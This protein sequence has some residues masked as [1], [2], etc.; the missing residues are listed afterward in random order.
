MPSP[1]Q[2]KL[3]PPA[4]RQFINTS[5]M[6]TPLHGVIGQ[7]SPEAFLQLTMQQVSWLRAPS[8]AAPSRAEA[9]ESADPPGVTV[10]WRLLYASP[11]T[12]T[13]SLGISTRF[14]ITP[15]I[16]AR[17]CKAYYSTR[18]YTAVMGFLSTQKLSLEDDCTGAGCG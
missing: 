7:L 8:R 4:R 17:H 14:P 13:G 18:D 1:Q 16:T 6:Q 9:G 11:L 15:A 10:Q 2:E 5:K 12:V 3:P